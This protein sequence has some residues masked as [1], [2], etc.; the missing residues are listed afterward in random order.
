LLTVIDA[1]T[2]EILTEDIWLPGY[3]S[4]IFGIE[5]LELAFVA[6]ETT[7][8]VISPQHVVEQNLPMGS[9]YVTHGYAH[10]ASQRL[11]VGGTIP[12][13]TPDRA[14]LVI[15]PESSAIESDPFQQAPPLAGSLRA[16]P[17][18]F[19]RSLTLRWD[20][21]AALPFRIA[22]FD[23]TGR[24]IRTIDTRGA[25]GSNASQSGQATWD[26]TDA[27]GAPLPS[28]IYFY[29]LE[30]GGGTSSPAGSRTSMSGK[31]LLLH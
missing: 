20:L 13:P 28:G 14:V 18:P 21:P 3:P 10:P 15:E 23:A 31:V 4:S 22:I 9:Y 11:L 30:C 17:N 7:L 6:A 26:G 12:P 2:L 16:S 29:S 27:R 5:S 1:K 8:A 25:E 19:R 24:L